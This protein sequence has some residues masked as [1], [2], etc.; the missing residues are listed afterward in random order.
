MMR[1]ICC[2]A[3]ALTGGG[4]IRLKKHQVGVSGKEIK[5]REPPHILVV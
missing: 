1:K 5:I 2:V 3:V 4:I